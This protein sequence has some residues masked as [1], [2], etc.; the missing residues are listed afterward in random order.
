[1]KPLLLTVVAMALLAGP[2]AAQPITLR[3]S[4]FLGPAGFFQVDLV[5]P[6]ARELEAR[7][8]GRVAVEILDCGTPQGKVTEQ[9]TNLRNGTVD[10][11]LGLRGAE[12]DRFPRS[13]LIELPFMIT[14]ARRGSMVLWDMF[15]RGAFG[16]EY[17]GY[18]VLALA[19]H[20]PGLIHTADRPVINP[21]D[22][23]GL[24]LRSPNA[25][26]SAALEQLG[27]KPVLLQ[28]NDVM[29]ALAGGRIEGIV[30]NWGNPLPGFNDGV[31]YHADIRFY[32]SVFFILMNQDRYDSLPADIR[33][34]IDQMSGAVLSERFGELW[35][36]W[37]APVRAGANAPGHR[38]V[39]PDAAAMAAW[40]EALAPVTNGYVRSLAA[41]GFAGAQQVYDEMQEL[42]AA[43]R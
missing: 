20:N 37:D 22:V 16:P 35:N 42:L 8:G 18:K 4:Q 40:R 10:I 29:P 2:A 31:R 25:T 24:R 21:A 9:A 23:T 36:R 13:S 7:T 28:V 19:V 30:T 33:Q 11:A 39:V 6:W 5:T 26:V 32:T 38:I 43:G 12:G 34:T 17:A 14:D 3:F 41:G 15:S 27:A 1:M